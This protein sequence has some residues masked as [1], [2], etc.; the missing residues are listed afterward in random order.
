MTGMN[1]VLVVKDGRVVHAELGDRGS[2]DVL[3]CLCVALTWN[4]GRFSFSE[5][6]VNAKD[7]A[8]DIQPT[9]ALLLDASRKLDELAPD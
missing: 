3:D 7:A 6:A 2:C 5:Q 8:G 1:A 4:S 9:T